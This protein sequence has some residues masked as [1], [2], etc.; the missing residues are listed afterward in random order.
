MLQAVTTYSGPRHKLF[1][2]YNLLK[3]WPIFTLFSPFYFECLKGF[4]EALLCGVGR[5]PAFL[6]KNM[7]SILS[8][9]SGSRLKLR[10]FAA[11]AFHCL[12]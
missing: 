3:L 12:P 5:L 4:P 9:K 8:T 11:C 10:Q 2:A 7:M 6:T 1:I